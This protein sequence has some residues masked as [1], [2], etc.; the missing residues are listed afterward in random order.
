MQQIKPCLCIHQRGGSMELAEQRSPRRGR[1]QPPHLLHH[2]CSRRHQRVQCHHHHPSTR[3]GQRQPLPLH[4]LQ[5]INK[6]NNRIG[7]GT[8][9]E[10]ALGKSSHSQRNW[11]VQNS[12]LQWFMGGRI[13][14][15]WWMRE[16]STLTCPQWWKCWLIQLLLECQQSMMQQNAHKLSSMFQQQWHP[17]WPWILLNIQNLTTSSTSPMIV[18]T[19]TDKTP[20][21]WTW[22]L[23]HTDHG[24]RRK[25]KIQCSIPVCHHHIR[26]GHW[27]L[28][29]LTWTS[30]V[31]RQA[32][33]CHQFQ[34]MSASSTASKRQSSLPPGQNMP[35]GDLLMTRDHLFNQ[36][37]WLHCPLQPQTDLPNLP[38]TPWHLHSDCHCTLAKDMSRLQHQKICIGK[39]GRQH[40]HLLASFE[41]ER[42]D[43]DQIWRQR[44]CAF[45]HT[46]MPSHCVF[47][48]QRWHSVGSRS[49]WFIQKDEKEQ[50][51]ASNFHLWAAQQSHCFC[52]ILHQK[53]EP[54]AVRLEVEN[55]FA[56]RSEKNDFTSQDCVCLH[57]VCADEIAS[58]LLELISSAD[59]WREW[60]KK[61]RSQ[62][63]LG[64]PGQKI[65]VRDSLDTGLTPCASTPSA[66]QANEIA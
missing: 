57:C 33:H 51:I 29:S 28:L 1:R 6:T 62:I 21:D 58:N 39:F 40:C 30:E 3:R 41:I 23:F 65:G 18:S 48:T 26:H 24:W 43:K 64:T 9:S 59:F 44:H 27:E 25:W 7:R 5:E 14:R 60:T 34:Q 13:N 46:D 49:K 15:Q 54:F 37:C 11:K 22:L 32:Q 63:A 2:P 12:K 17:Q 10:W 4:S 42:L 36:S 53:W 50:V 19:S 61:G 55:D 8:A 35:L 52:S 47:A 31:C 20:Q 16:D 45:T 56:K 38:R 66:P